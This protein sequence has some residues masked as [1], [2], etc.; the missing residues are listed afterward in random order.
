[1]QIDKAERGLLRF[2]LALSPPGNVARD[3]SL[4]RASLF[5]RFA[6][7][8]S[9]FMPE[10]VPLAFA[11]RPRD[12]APS[13]FSRAELDLAWEGISGGFSAGLPVDS[14]GFLYLGLRGP[15][16][17]LSRRGE[18]VLQGLGLVI[19]DDAPLAPGLGFPLCASSSAAGG[20]CAPPPALSFRDCALVV[21]R[22]R[23]GSTAF[24][25]AAWRELARARRPTGPS[26]TPSRRLARG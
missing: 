4:Y 16:E 7:A 12:A 2:M 19:A 3:L 25:A 18:G 1:M 6:D 11:R 24:S 21:A 14:R 23:F 26:Q 8:S 22:V 10:V 15:L 13:D 9:R 20:L 17:E 5:S